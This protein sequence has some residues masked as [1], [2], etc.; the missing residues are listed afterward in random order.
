[1]ARQGLLPAVLGRVHAERRTPHIAIFTLLVLV[2]GLALSGGVADLASATGLLLLFSFT[3]VNSA[4][5]VLK[6]R[7]SEPPGNFEVPVWVP[8]LGILVNVTLIVTRIA[9]GEG[10]LR[11]PLIAGLIVLAATILYFILRP[12]NLTDESLATLEE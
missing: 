7:A 9:T 8:M 1:M 4:L 12:T 6:F 11:A 5:V 3:V 10:G 2:T